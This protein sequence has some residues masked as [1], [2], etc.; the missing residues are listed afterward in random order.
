MGDGGRDG[1]DKLLLSRRGM[2]RA[3]GAAGA[4]LL[5]G[6]GGGA[7]RADVGCG[8]VATT[9]AAVPSGDSGIVP[10][11]GR[12]QAGIATPTQDHLHFAAFDVTVEDREQVRFLLR[13]WSGAAARLC[14][15]APLGSG[16]LPA[17]LPPEDTGEIAGYPPARLTV[18]IGFGPTLFESGGR[19]RFGLT[20][21]RPDALANLPA[22]PGDELDPARCGGDICVQACADDPQ[23]AFHA[24]RNVARLGAG[25]VRLRWAQLGFGRAASTTPDQETPRNLFG[26]KDGTNNVDAAD[27]AEMDRHVW[28]WPGDGP[29]WME[30]G[31]FLVARRIRM[32]VEAWDNASLESQER[33]IGRAKASGAPIGGRRERDALDLA[34]RGADGEPLIPAGAHVR[35]ARGDGRER[36][37][38]RGYSYADGLDQDGGLD[39]GLFFLC[40][41]RDPRRQF[42]PMQRRLAESDAINEYTTHTGSAVFA[43]PPG[44]GEGGYV[45]ETLFG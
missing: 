4:S 22:F 30:G 36:I 27:E 11:H 12:V 33:S 41:Q 43:C 18:T 6:S 19:D 5:L 38:R 28:V 39:A 8:A 17:Q 24:V 37:L 42:V 25:I 7:A 40:F 1:A 29:A 14:A 3:A 32:R 10:F 13:A 45:G 34:A 23:V 21:A 2:L 31:T 44:A 26:F 9:A 16:V 35:L 20:A 15:G